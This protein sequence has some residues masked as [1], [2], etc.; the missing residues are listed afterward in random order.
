[1]ANGSFLLN[2]S[3]VNHEHR[4]LAGKLIDEVGPPSQT[5]V[6]LE[7]GRSGPTISEKDPS[8]AV[9][10]G[11]EILTVSPICW[12]FLQFAVVGVLFCFSRWPIFG[13]PRQLP[14]DA[15]SDFGKHIRAVAELLGRSRDRAYAMARVLNYQQTTKPP[16]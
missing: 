7:S 14:A 4:K 11:M 12:I 2:A 8:A 10:T 3:L 9:P 5:V 6:F 1:V 16:E 13:L 15:P